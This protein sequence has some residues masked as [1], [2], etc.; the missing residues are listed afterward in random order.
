MLDFTLEFLDELVVLGVDFV[1]S[2]S[3]SHLLGA[4]GKFQG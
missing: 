3:N 4:F 1:F 2:K